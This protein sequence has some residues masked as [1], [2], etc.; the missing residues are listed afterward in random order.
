GG[1]GQDEMRE[2][3]L[4]SPPPESHGQGPLSPP[5][6]ALHDVLLQLES[7]VDEP[8]ARGLFLRLG[9]WGGAWGRAADLREGLSAIREAGKPIHCHFEIAD[10]ASFAILA[11]SCDRIT[12]TPAGV[13]DLVGPAAHVFYARS[14]LDSIGVRAEVLQVGRYKGTGDALTQEDMPEATR[15]ALGALLDDLHALLLAAILPR[16]TSEERARALIDAGPYGASQALAAGLIDDIEF[17]DEAREHARIAARDEA[18]LEDRGFRV[19]RVQAGPRSEP[20]GLAEI[21]DALSGA[22]DEEPELGHRI[23]LIQ[24]EGS[25]TDGD[26]SSD[27]AGRS[28]P[29]VTKLREL[30]DDARVRAVVLRIDSPGGSALASDRMWHAVRRVAARKPVIV[31]VGDM[32]ASGGYYIASAGTEIFAHPESLLGS[33]GVVG[34]KLDVSAL[35]DRMGV[36]PVVIQRG[37]HAAWSSPVVALGEEERGVL[38]DLLWQTYSRFLRRVGEGRSMDR[39]AV[40][41]GAEGRIMTGRAALALGLIDREGGLQQALARAH[42]LAEAED[43]PIDVWPPR[44]GILDALASRMGG[45]QGAGS[46]ADPALGGRAALEPGLQ[47]LVLGAWEL[48]RESGADA[49]LIPLIQGDHPIALALPYGLSLR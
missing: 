9:S 38:R 2:L 30:G 26:R 20:L 25:I 23:A 17:D 48:A 32:A 37:E 7:I 34:G 41:A 44:R 42:E 33:I 5:T 14:L 49:L 22:P 10:N 12:M 45:A 15:E 21:L 29:F 11:S 8:S 6:A 46:L 24:L 18:G 39:E 13:L 1:Q 3:L 40:M 47:G 31:S 19:R 4:D 36:H 16:A 28:G 35:A 27:E 43:L